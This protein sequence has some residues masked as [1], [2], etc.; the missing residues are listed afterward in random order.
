M[1]SVDLTEKL[2]G[3]LSA[4]TDEEGWAHLGRIPLDS[5]TVLRFESELYGTQSMRW[6]SWGQLPRGGTIVLLPVGG[7]RGQ[8]TGE[9]PLGGRTV[10]LATLASAPQGSSSRR[11]RAT[12]ETDDEGYFAVPA[13]AAGTLRL[14]VAPTDAEPSGGSLTEEFAVEVGGR[15]D[16]TLEIERALRV[17]GRLVEAGSGE[18][19]PEVDVL[20]GALTATSGRTDGEGRFAGWT[21][22][23]TFSVYVPQAPLPYCG[24]THRRIE[25]ATTDDGELRLEDLTLERGRTLRGTVVD[26]RDEPLPGAW[27]KALGAGGGRRSSGWPLIAITD[28]AGRFELCGLPVEGEVEVDA[29][30]REARLAEPRVVDPDSE[31]PLVIALSAGD[32]VLPAGR[33]LGPDGAPV[34]GATVELWERWEE[35]GR[36]RTESVFRFHPNLL[37]LTDAEGHFR[38]PRPLPN[39]GTFRATVSVPGYPP[40]ETE[41]THLTDPEATHLPDL[42]LEGTRTITGVI[43]DSDGAPVAEARVFQSGDGPAAT[44][45]VTDAEG[46]FELGGFVAGPVWLFAEKTGYRFQGSATPERIELRRLDEPPAG[47]TGTLP[48]LPRGEELAV[49]R[50]LYAEL[51][52]E[53]RESGNRGALLRPLGLRS[54]Y[55]PLG[56]LDEL[57][58]S[59]LPQAWFRDS[60]RRKV[61]N[62]LLRSDVEEA[63]AVAATMEG[64]SWR[65][66]SLLDAA[67]ILWE[68]REEERREILAEA[69]VEARA[70]EDPSS[71]LIKLSRVAGGFADVEDHDAARS[72]L[73]EALELAEELPPVDLDAFVPGYCAVELAAYDLET[74]LALVAEIPDRLEAD[75][76]RHLASIAHELADR[77]PAAAERVLARVKHWNQERILPRVVHRMAPVDL[78]RARRLARTIESPYLR[79]HAEAGI[80][81]ALVDAGGDAAGVAPELLESAY[82][83]LEAKAC[84]GEHVGS[85]SSNAAC[86]AAALLPIVERAAPERLPEFFWRSLAMRPPWP[87]PRLGTEGLGRDATLALLLARYDR[88]VARR[89][90]DRHLERLHE[91]TTRGGELRLLFPAVAAID[92]REGAELLRRAQAS[93]R[94]ELRRVAKEARYSVAGLLARAG[95]ER[96]KYAVR[97]GVRL[98]DLDEED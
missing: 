34:A 80:A 56:V 3:R 7:V 6:Q 37:I 21:A 81:L 72:I 28:D 27:V 52:R 55:D 29:Q 87:E 86:V 43:I 67:A 45:T 26:E 13:I 77:D 39:R 24:N 12:V 73:A 83:Q 94:E 91:L 50:A 23:T 51:E 5:I 98:K 84:S 76:A 1:G 36:E 74:A 30:R 33:V 59:P 40:A 53:A 19:V 2:E 31:E 82:A 44:E 79:A 89:L 66:R 96:S 46:R 71:R 25:D 64:A 20:L 49:V 11:G 60:L 95:G 97:M 62:T 17:T 22:T 69:L 47:P 78:P 93:E 15:L 16:L 54:L 32:A 68:E 75:P 38:A 90:L 57:K 9:G 18:P 58:T 85:G 35:G 65:C 10:E 61:A 8:L 4:T 92:P 42:L 41:W 70:I 88:G 14:W 63:L 48:P